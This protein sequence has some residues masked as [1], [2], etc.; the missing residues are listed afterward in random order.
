M[1][2]TPLDA[3]AV[4]WFFVLM[5][6]GSVAHGNFVAYTL[7]YNSADCS[8]PAGSFGATNQATCTPATCSQLGLV[9]HQSFCY[10]GTLAS[11]ANPIV[12][13]GC[14]YCG[15]VQYPAGGNCSNPNGWTT[16]TFLRLGACISISGANWVRA[17]GCTVFG[18]INNYTQYAD[19]SCT[20]GSLT[21]SNTPSCDPQQVNCQVP[22]GLTG[23][24]QDYCSYGGLFGGG[25][26]GPNNTTAPAAAASVQGGLLLLLAVLFWATL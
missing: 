1:S 23:P 22:P 9:S 11:L 3:V 13:A 8:G 15:N 2:T 7:Q 19:G 18:E 14:A 20:Q 12:C 17:Y 16:A 10:A 5:G 4:F 21:N 24:G 25:G 26:G 6:C